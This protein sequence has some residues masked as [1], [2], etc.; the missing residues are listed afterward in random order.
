MWGVSES[1]RVSQPRREKPKNAVKSI[2]RVVIASVGILAVVV[3]LQNG[4]H[5]RP[6]VGGPETPKIGG[7]RAPLL[8][9]A[10]GA[11]LQRHHIQHGSSR[12]HGRDVDTELTELTTYYSQPAAA[13][14]ASSSRTACHSKN[15][16]A[17]E[18]VSL[19]MA[20]PPPACSP[21]VAT[22]RGT[23]QR[24][25]SSRLPRSV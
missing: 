4:G 20:T 23:P 16:D 14:P 19:T 25:D 2:V 9:L 8:G 21:G 22:R 13:P 15:K 5:A 18:S 7:A 6:Q 24:Q 1:C 17:T 12:R 3:V 11:R 10:Q